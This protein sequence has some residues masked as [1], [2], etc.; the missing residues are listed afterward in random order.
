MNGIT[1]TLLA[2]LGISTCVSFCLWNDVINGVMNKYFFVPK[3]LYK[4]L[5]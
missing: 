1:C 2:F 3:Y 5:L 4:K